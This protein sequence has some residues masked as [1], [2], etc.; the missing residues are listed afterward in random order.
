MTTFS[1]LGIDISKKTFDVALLLPSG[2][3]KH[4]KF[5][6]T[7]DGFQG[8][9]DWL[10]AFDLTKIHACMEATNVY[11]NALAEYLY[12]QGYDVIQPGAKGLPGVSCYA[13]RTTNKMHL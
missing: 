5:P 13:P 3:Q 2:K 6:N 9:F 12:D 11:G 4:K 7:P 1:F 10:Q 8:L